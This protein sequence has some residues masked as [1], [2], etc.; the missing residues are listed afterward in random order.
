VGSFD[1]RGIFGYRNRMTQRAQQMLQHIIDYCN[2]KWMEADQAKPSAYESADTHNGR[3]AAYNDV[4]QHA[5][6]LLG[7]LSEKP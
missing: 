4:F 3:K 2:A 1:E 6:T 7:E 5:R